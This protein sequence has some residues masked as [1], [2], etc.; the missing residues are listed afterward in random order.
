[1]LRIFG[2]LAGLRASLPLLLL[3]VAACAMGNERPPVVD[4]SNPIELDAST[5]A[6]AS[7]ALDAFK[8]KNK[9]WQCFNVSM[10]SQDGN[11]RV[12]FVPSDDVQ[13]VDGKLL[14]GASKC[15]EGVSYI[16]NRG[17]KIIRVIYGR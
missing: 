7:V 12:D 6:L 11:W 13:Q 10:Y 1:M 4:E 17:G 2:S 16:V 5:L 3:A 14:V 8:A 9:H 15:G